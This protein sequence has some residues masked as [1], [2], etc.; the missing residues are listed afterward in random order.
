[1]SQKHLGDCVPGREN[2]KHN[3]KRNTLG[4]SEEQQKAV[5]STRVW[6][7]GLSLTEEIYKIEAR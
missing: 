1:M 3:R 2:S 6:A 4:I 7:V 5:N